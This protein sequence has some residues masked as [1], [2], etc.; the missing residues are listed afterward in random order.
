MKNSPIFQVTPTKFVYGGE[1]MGRLPDGRAVFIP[2]ALPGDTVKVALTEDKDRYARG[3]V[4]ELLQANP[5]RVVP[6]CAH[7]GECGGCHYQHLPYYEQLQVK[8]SVLVEQLERIGKFKDPPV[9]DMIPSPYPFNYRSSMRFHLTPAGQLGF[10]RALDHSVLPIHECH[11]PEPLLDEI[12]P[13]LELDAVP[14]L[15]SVSLRSGQSGQDVLLSLESSDPSPI[16]FSVDLPLSAVHLGPGGSLILAGDDFT[17][18][19]VLGVSFVVSAGSFFQVNIPIAELIVTHVLELISPTESS[20]ILDV[21]CGGGLF[22]YFLA[23]RSGLV[24]GIES[25]PPS[26]EDFM[27]NLREFENVELYEAPAEEVLPFLEIPVDAIL[28]DPPRAGLDRK[29]LD[30]ILS[31]AP[32]TVVYVSCD[33]ATLSRDAKRLVRGGYELVKVTPFDMFPQTFHIE[34]VSLFR[35]RD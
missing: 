17:L 9:E 33:P 2:F 14:G 15:D 30:G 26:A 7:F 23:P 16:E 27:D 5:N 8:H 31:L 28:V 25:S 18:V 3:R 1:V 29:A 4:V 11:L 19:D 13:R 6:R 10:Y 35:K 22:S 12:W 32:D 24:I 20:T 34:S 21:Y